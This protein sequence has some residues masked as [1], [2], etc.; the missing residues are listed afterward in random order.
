MRVKTSMFCSLSRNAH[1]QEWLLK[2]TPDLHEDLLKTLAKGSCHANK[3]KMIGHLVLIKQRGLVSEFEKLIRERFPYV[4]D[5]EGSTSTPQK[6]RE[7]I[8]PLSQ[9][10]GIVDLNKHKI[11]KA[12]HPHILSYPAKI[13]IVGKSRDDVR[14]R[15]YNFIR[16]KIS[17]DWIIVEDRAYVEYFFE[18]HR[19]TAAKIKAEERE[20]AQYRR[21][22]NLAD[23]VHET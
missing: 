10:R 3:E 14:R 16:S 20:I 21:K 13:I 7:K 4:E 6:K 11:F 1:W 18:Q 17:V 9:P 5:K 8:I 19:E 2:H 23:G 12:Y 22:N 15:V